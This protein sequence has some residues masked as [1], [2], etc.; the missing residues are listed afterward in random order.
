MPP[1][2]FG[3]LVLNRMELARA[4]EHVSIVLSFTP[5]IPVYRDE[6]IATFSDGIRNCLGSLPEPTEGGYFSPQGGTTDR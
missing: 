3:S 5:C 1:S 4:D 6:R 2:L